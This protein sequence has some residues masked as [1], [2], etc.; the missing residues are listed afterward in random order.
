MG[1]EVHPEVMQHVAHRPP[2][3]PSHAIGGK[4]LGFGRRVAVELFEVMLD[5]FV[6]EVIDGQARIRREASLAPLELDSAM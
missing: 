6:T 1:F 2:P 4:L 3:V 5:A